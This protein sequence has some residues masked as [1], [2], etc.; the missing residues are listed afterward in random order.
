MNERAPIVTWREK[1]PEA[2]AKPAP[3]VPGTPIRIPPN[4]R[5][6]VRA[7]LR[8]IVVDRRVFVIARSWEEG[9]PPRRKIVFVTWYPPEA[10]GEVGASRRT[11]LLVDCLVGSQF[12][13]ALPSTWRQIIPA[14]AGA[15]AAGVRQTTY[16]KPEAPAGGRQT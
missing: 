14:I 12:R 8:R 10:R 3:Y 13:R 1:K 4:V 16:A 11:G 15:I 5:A 2:P 7:A 6:G 9:R